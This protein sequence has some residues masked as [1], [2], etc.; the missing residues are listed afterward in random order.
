MCKIILIHVPYILQVPGRQ[1]I[2]RPT[3]TTAV[4]KQKRDKRT[5]KIDVLPISTEWIYVV[6]TCGM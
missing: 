1:L 3:I 4:E 5:Y 6:Q 2:R